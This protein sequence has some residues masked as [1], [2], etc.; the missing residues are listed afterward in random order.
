MYGSSSDR[1][2]AR[3]D[4]ICANFA[5]GGEYPHAKNDSMNTTGNNSNMQYA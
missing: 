3:D 5:H 1:C 2:N 4:I